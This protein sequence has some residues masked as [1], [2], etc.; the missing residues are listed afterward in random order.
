MRPCAGLMLALLLA[1]GGGGGGGDPYGESPTGPTGNNPNTPTTPTTPSTSAS[2]EMVSNGDGYG[3]AVHQF[4]PTRVTVAR[5]GTVTW[6]NTSGFA[7]NVTFSSA[8]AP[9]HIDDF[10]TGNVSRTF[11]SAG[12]FGYSCQNHAGMSG[13]VVVP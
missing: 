9:P 5:G 8:S 7:H 13:E 10:T 1:C 6:S 11:P 2:V 12:T 3:G 4:S